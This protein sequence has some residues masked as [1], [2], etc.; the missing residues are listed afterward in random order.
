VNL[1]LFGVCV[2]PLC[3]WFGWVNPE[4][5]PADWT[6]GQIFCGAMAVIQFFAA[7]INLI[8]LPPLDGF[9]IVRPY[10]P[11]DFAAKVR[12]PQISFGI[13]IVLFFIRGSRDG[14]EF[15]FGA[16]KGAMNLLHVD[17]YTQECIFSAYDRAL[18][19]PNR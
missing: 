17:L 7:L 4:A 2:A 8:P 10:L 9:N 1:I 14:G 15:M 6:P 12:D 3:P 19:G 16:L 13:L 5:S 11:A 18:F